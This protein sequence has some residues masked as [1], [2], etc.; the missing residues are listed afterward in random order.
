MK[1]QT[2]IVSL[3]VILI[4]AVV[5]SPHARA[6]KVIENPDVTIAVDG[7]ACPFCAYGL[8]KKLKKVDGIEDL[9]VQMD[10]GQVQIKVREGADV[11]EKQIRDAVVD[12]GFTVT[13][14]R[15]EG[16]KEGAGKEG[17]EG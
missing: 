11:T 2:R 15:F 14:I 4:I 13:Q 1:L 6:Q 3:F 16:K 7:L 8:E 12:A 10:E 17:S 5:L 9:A